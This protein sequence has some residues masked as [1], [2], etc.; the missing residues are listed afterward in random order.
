MADWGDNEA[1]QTVDLV[2]PCLTA[3]SLSVYIGHAVPDP[4]RLRPADAQ[5]DH[6]PHGGV[7]LCRGPGQEIRRTG[8]CCTPD[9]HKLRESFIPVHQSSSLLIYTRRSPAE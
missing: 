7:G 6:Q 8:Q 2:N 3:A 9:T 1:P 4:A 5:C